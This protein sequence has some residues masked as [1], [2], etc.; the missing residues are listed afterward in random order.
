MESL[1]ASLPQSAPQFDT[2]RMSD[3]TLLAVCLGNRSA[4]LYELGRHKVTSLSNT[5]TMHTLSSPLQECLQDIE[6]ALKLGVS[7]AIEQKL[8]KR[9]RKLSLPVERDLLQ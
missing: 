7:A 9:K 3:E 6:L 8:L 2:S 4:A 5:M 1:L